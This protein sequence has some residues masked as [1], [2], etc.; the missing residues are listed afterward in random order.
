MVCIILVWYIAAL[1]KSFARAAIFLRLNIL[2]LDKKRC[3][4]FSRCLPAYARDKK[5]ENF[6]K[7]SNIFAFVLLKNVKIY[8]IINKKILYLIRYGHAGENFAR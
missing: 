3:K 5:I 8:D 6:L 4:F 7:N 1:A 2:D